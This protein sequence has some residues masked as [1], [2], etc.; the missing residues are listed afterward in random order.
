MD[1]PLRSCAPSTGSGLRGED[2]APAARA[3]LRRQPLQGC[4]EVPEVGR[5]SSSGSP[6]GFAQLQ[7]RD[8]Y[9]G[10]LWTGAPAPSGSETRCK[11]ALT[12]V[13]PTQAERCQRHGQGLGRTEVD[14]V[15]EVAEPEKKKPGLEDMLKLMLMSFQVSI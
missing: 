15:V 8:I 2:G 12:G 4:R 6:A 5:C 1:A 11:P 14:E 3:A 7:R 13:R 9:G 10:G